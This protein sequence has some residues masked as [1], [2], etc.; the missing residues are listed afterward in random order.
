MK[1]KTRK[2]IT[3]RRERPRDRYDQ[4]VERLTK[5]PGE[6]PRAWLYGWGHS[7]LFDAIGMERGATVSAPCGCPIEIRRGHSA[8]TKEL[9][10]RIGQDDR[11]PKRVEEISPGHLPIFAAWQRIADKELGRKPP[12][13]LQE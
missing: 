12:R 4:E 11:L 10:D 6:I 9:T 1:T 13:M 3:P 5:Y 2:R 7:P 8:E